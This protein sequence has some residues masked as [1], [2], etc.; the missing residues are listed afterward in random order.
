MRNVKQQNEKMSKRHDSI[1]GTPSSHSHSHSSMAPSSSLVTKSSH[2]HP[3]ASCRQKRQSNGRCEHSP[4]SQSPLH[5]APSGHNL[6]SEQSS[7][8]CTLPATSS[9]S[10]VSL[11]HQ[12]LIGEQPA[13]LFSSHTTKP[14]V[15]ASGNHNTG[16]QLKPSTVESPAVATPS[17]LLVSS[18]RAHTDGLL[19]RPTN[20]TKFS[21]PAHSPRHNVHADGQ[22]LPLSSTPLIS[23]PS[24]SLKSGHTISGEQALRPITTDNVPTPVHSLPSLHHTGK[25]LPPTST[26]LISTPSRSLQSASRYTAPAEQL[27]Q[28]RTSTGKVSTPLA[29]PH[30]TVIDRRSLQQSSSTALNVKATPSR[31]SLASLHKAVSGAQSLR[32]T[33]TDKVD[34][35]TPVH[36]LATLAGVQP[37]RVLDATPVHSLKPT[38]FARPTSSGRTAQRSSK[39]TAA[40][41]ETMAD[42]HSPSS[43]PTTSAVS[44]GHSTPALS[45]HSMDNTPLPTPCKQPAILSHTNTTAQLKSNVYGGYFGSNP[46]STNVCVSDFTPSND[47]LEGGSSNENFPASWKQG[48]RYSTHHHNHH[49]V[50]PTRSSGFSIPSSRINS[51]DNRS[52]LGNE[53]RPSSYHSDIKPDVCGVHQHTR[54]DGPLCHHFGNVER[55]KC[56]NV[57][58]ATWTGSNRA[59]CG[60]TYSSTLHSPANSLAVEIESGMTDSLCPSCSERAK[61]DH[62]DNRRFS[63]DFVSHQSSA[64]LSSCSPASLG[65]GQTQN[66]FH[67]KIK[68]INH[69]QLAQGDDSV[70]RQSP[71]DV[72][73]RPERHMGGGDF[74]AKSTS[75]NVNRAQ[76]PV[77]TSTP[78]RRR[79]ELNSRRMQTQTPYREVAQGR[80]TLME[81]SV[82]LPQGMGKT[83]HFAAPSL[84][85]NV[86]AKQSVSK[87]SNESSPVRV[88]HSSDFPSCFPKRRRNDEM[89]ATSTHSSPACSRVRG[90]D[91]D[92]YSSAHSSSALRYSEV[93]RAS[94]PVLSTNI[95]SSVR[96]RRE[97]TINYRHTTDRERLAYL[98]PLPSD[99]STDS[100]SSY[101]ERG[102]PSRRTG[103][104]DDVITPHA[105]IH[106]S[107]KRASNRVG[108]PLREHV[109]YSKPDS[110][111]EHLHIYVHGHG[112]AKPQVV[113]VVEAPKIKKK[114]VVYLT[115]RTPSPREEVQFSVEPGRFTPRA[116]SQRKRVA[117]IAEGIGGTSAARRRSIDRSYVSGVSRVSGHGRRKK[118]VYLEPT[119][120]SPEKKVYL[121][122]QSSDGTDSDPEQFGILE[123]SFK[124]RL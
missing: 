35:S 78:S 36:S 97:P 124:I 67:P 107:S 84:R 72:Q 22:S 37:S 47:L 94:S 12:S 60:S 93:R 110:G 46:S 58:V 121:V 49:L 75:I 83:E 111:L 38:P 66:R 42:K 63:D 115:S 87:A 33:T 26:A 92:T 39:S 44:L 71:C 101:H 16:E 116:S 7:N 70:R 21:T 59:I 123:V 103:S 34:V 2:E 122:E 80:E 24:I 31:S 56:D 23:T 55:H 119:S 19:S 8:T 114:R 68:D 90:S 6:G 52:S 99:S 25:P 88:R 45:A 54:S 117:G 28:S 62:H 15:A 74:S 95:H 102:T 43:S 32:S 104:L 69:Y 76:R 17:Q 51:F 4:V 79:A 64:S 30:H 50:Q 20:T 13:S 29:S 57:H 82:T 27:L 41:K 65:K 53:D 61:R 98:T 106:T 85:N 118:R 77:A 10:T 100:E 105:H 1:P 113:K 89:Y 11:S 3:L 112:D 86:K 109:H 108:K 48:S 14:L 81:E 73:A 9:L 40:V 91:S 120:S 18:H 5:N 96:S